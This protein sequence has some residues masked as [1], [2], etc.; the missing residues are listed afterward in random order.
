MLLSVCAFLAMASLLTADIDEGLMQNRDPITPSNPA[1]V[2]EYIWTYMRE[3]DP[4]KIHWLSFPVVDDQTFTNGVGRNW[5]GYI[6]EE[7]KIASFDGG[8]DQIRWSYDGFDGNM[9][10]MMNCWAYD[11]Y[12]VTQAKGFKVKYFRR[13]Q[14]KPITV[15]GYKADP[16]TTPVKW[17]VGRGNFGSAS[18]FE[19]WIGYFVPYT[20]RVGD[21]LSGQIPNSGGRTYLDYVHR[22]QAHTW[23]TCRLDAEPDSPWIIDPNRFTLSEGDMLALLLLPGAPTEMFW[24]SL[25][26]QVMPVKKAPARAFRSVEKLDYTPVFIEFDPL[27]RPDE[28]GLYV[29]GLCRGAAV[30][31]SNLVDLCFYRDSSMDGAD[32]QVRLHYQDRGTVTADNWKLYNPETMLFEEKRIDIP[33]IGRYAYLSFRHEVNDSLIPLAT[34]MAPFYLN[35]FNP[36]TNISFILAKDMDARLEIYNLRGQRVKTLCNTQHSKGKHTYVWTGQD[37]HGRQ[38]ASGIYFSRLTTPE[39][40]YTQKMMLMK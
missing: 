20:Q 28:V 24:S 16:A 3:P 12:E 29:D 10:F 30:V 14:D 38:V 37:D 33:R 25:G 27:D 17:V 7:H 13:G 32:L 15:K 31:D 8:L 40:N 35:P 4:A 5:L 23:S 6:F 34:G 22:I 1:Q 21:A 39:G 18:P 9:M 11:N 26:I 19:N 36:S 2:S